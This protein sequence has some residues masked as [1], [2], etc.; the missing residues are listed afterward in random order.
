MDDDTLAPFVD[1]LASALIMMVLVCIF[2]LVQTATEIQSAAKLQPV[3]NIKAGVSFTPITYR[4]IY[5]SNLE[6][7][8]FS[9][10][11][12]F[13]LEDELVEQIKAQINA[14]ISTI[15]EL[16]ITIESN[17]SGKKSTVN[18][19]RFIRYLNLDHDVKISTEIHPSDSV[20]SKVKWEIN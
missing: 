6:T 17:D 18:I 20:L 19:L 14:Q 13:V 8:E 9:Y 1:A 16:K 11:V 5:S 2:F 10:I 15:K 7:K 12:N 3:A 4:E